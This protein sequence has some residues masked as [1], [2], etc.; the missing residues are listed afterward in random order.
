MLS[1]MEGSEYVQLK[2]YPDVIT[3]L[4][5]AQ[6]L[7]IDKNAAYALVQGGTIGHLKVGRKYL[8]PKRCV[9][10]FLNSPRYNDPCNGGLKSTVTKG[11]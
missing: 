11:A 3:V 10:D 1:G 4:Q 8:V 2:D 9:I 7:G 5:L 6:V